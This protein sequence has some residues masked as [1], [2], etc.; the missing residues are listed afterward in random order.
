LIGLGGVALDARAVS[1]TDDPRE[2]A[3]AARWIAGNLLAIRRIPV[4]LRGE[5]PR[6]AAVLGLDAWDLT[7]VLAAIAVVPALLDPA[8][9]AWPWRLAL[10]ALGLPIVDRPRHEVLACGA[11]IARYGV[12][13]ACTLVVEANHIVRVERK[14]VIGRS[15]T[16]RARALHSG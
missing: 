5:P 7:G 11:S 6:E 3:L 9:L 10:R 15:L 13:E 1:R 8:T 16:P 4:A 12:D 14:V 2:R